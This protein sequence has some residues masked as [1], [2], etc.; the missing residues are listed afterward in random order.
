[1]FVMDVHFTS[2]HYVLPDTVTQ[3]VIL[4]AASEHMLP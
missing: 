2:P 1:M 3:W 4:F